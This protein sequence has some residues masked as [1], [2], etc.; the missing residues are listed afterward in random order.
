[1]TSN[2]ASA[3][4]L[5]AGLNPGLPPPGG[6]SA[7]VNGGVFLKNC[8]M[9]RSMGSRDGSW[10]GRV[11]V[12]LTAFV[13]SEWELSEET[14]KVAKEELHEDP[15][16]RGDYVETVQEMTVSRPD[17]RFL[18]TDDAFVLRFLRARKFC[19][20][21]AFQLFAKYFEYRQRNQ[22]LF[23]NFSASESGIRDALFDGFPGVLP[24]RDHFGR[25]ILTMYTSN[26][27][28]T[29]YSLISIYRA[30]L[31]TLEKLIEV[32]ET[33]IHGFVM[34]VDWTEFTFKQSTKLS[35]KILKLIVEGLQDC[36][37]ARFGGIHFIN[38]PWYV[39]A[40]F[41]VIRPFLKEKNRERIFMHGNNLTGLHHQIHKDILPAELGGS[42]PPYNNAS[43]AQQLVGDDSSF[44]FS[45]KQIFWP[46][47]GGGSPPVASPVTLVPPEPET[48]P[49]FRDV[50]IPEL[51]V[52]EDSCDV[53][54]QPSWDDDVVTSSGA[55]ISGIDDEDGRLRSRSETFPCDP[56]S[57]PAA[58]G[59]WAS[60]AAWTPTPVQGIHTTP[61]AGSAESAGSGACSTTSSGCVSNTSSS[62]FSSGSS[63]S[64]FSSSTSYSASRP[65][66]GFPS[67]LSSNS[68]YRLRHQMKPVQLDE[69]F[70][71]S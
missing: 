68:G 2:G 67:S 24:Y 70:F 57:M 5:P 51:P 50:D 14:L 32:P 15:E 47:D 69:D 30:V 55:A 43:W 6:G 53:P 12:L 8:L 29:H 41:K 46:K 37:P 61:I 23:H 52:H 49:R 54:W 34:I 4:G 26:W 65:S 31:L 63:G 28:E 18:R 40:A 9:N 38:Q 39:E 44:A 19:H 21:E 33:Q 17:L 64:S 48:I 58:V 20:M 56:Y 60:D 59:C 25:V 27:D 45:D 66:T 36:F 11:D 10:Q 16:T 7:S 1:M 22:N 62:G 35:P 13:P 3:F 71:L 42:A